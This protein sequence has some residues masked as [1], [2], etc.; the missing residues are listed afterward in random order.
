MAGNY[1]FGLDATKVQL[2]CMIFLQLDCCVGFSKERSADGLG[3]WNLSE[4]RTGGLPHPLRLLQP[5]V[6]AS[7]ISWYGVSNTCKSAA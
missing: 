3:N 5:H 6:L 1:H 7:E 2:S 4:A